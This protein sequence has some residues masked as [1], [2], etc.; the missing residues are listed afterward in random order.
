MRAGPGGGK[1][2]CRGDGL[3]AL[4][5]GEL[6]ALPLE[7]LVLLLEFESDCAGCWLA[8]GHLVWA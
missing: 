3:A 7:L 4:V 6:L 5:V 1:L 8:G 2:L